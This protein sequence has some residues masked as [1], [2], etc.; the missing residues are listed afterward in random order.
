VKLI[1]DE[2]VL[3]QSRKFLDAGASRLIESAYRM[4]RR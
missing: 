4:F 1:A 2:D 3:Q